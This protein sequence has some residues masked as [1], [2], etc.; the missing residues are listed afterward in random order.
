[1]RIDALLTPAELAAGPKG[2]VCVVLDILRATTSMVAA[3][4]NGAER[5]VCA[6]D[7][8]EARRLRKRH[9]AALLAGERGGLKVPGFDLGNSPSEFRA[10]AVRGRTV[11]MSTTNGTRAVRACA[12]ARRVYVG[13]LTNLGATVR[14][15]AAYAGARKLPVKLVCSG[16]QQDFSWE[17]A[18]AAGA[19]VEAFSRRLPGWEPSD[20]ALAVRALYASE[21][22]RLKAALGRGRNGRRLKALG[23]SA[24]LAYSSALDASGV[25]ALAG[26]AG[27]SASS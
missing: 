8:A 9:P 22:G 18:L 19:Y 1:M 23:L 24:D 20:A 2:S 17:D 13:A 14:A 11:I 26:A 12:L 25:C 16:T 15:A 7:P 3:L 5:V 4:E 6:L 21:R 27:V 10:S